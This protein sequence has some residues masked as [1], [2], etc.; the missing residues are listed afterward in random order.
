MAGGPNA[1]DINEELSTDIPWRCGRFAA[2]WLGGHQLQV[3]LLCCP[4]GGGLFCLQLPSTAEKEVGQPVT[5]LVSACLLEVTSNL[6][7]FT[8]NF[9]LT[10]FQG[11]LATLYR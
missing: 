10:S 9:S 2:C 6:G 4:T 8:C 7:I 3:L 5:L 11:G 1:E